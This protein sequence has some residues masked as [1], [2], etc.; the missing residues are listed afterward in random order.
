MQTSLMKFTLGLL[1]FVVAPPK[2]S[3][4]AVTGLNVL[5]EPVRFRIWFLK[6][7]QRLVSN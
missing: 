7:R 2:N 1:L 5:K 6:Q 3:P 4:L